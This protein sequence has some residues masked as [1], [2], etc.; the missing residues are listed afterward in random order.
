MQVVLE[1]A[2]LTQGYGTEHTTR[3]YI[4]PQLSLNW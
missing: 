2:N 4:N 3:N 1:L